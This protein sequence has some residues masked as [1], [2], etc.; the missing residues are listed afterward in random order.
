MAPQRNASKKRPNSLISTKSVIAAI[1]C[2][3]SGRRGK[4]L[5]KA[6]ISAA[7][8]SWRSRCQAGRIADFDSSSGRIRPYAA[9]DFLG[10][11]IAAAARE[12]GCS[13]NVT[14]VNVAASGTQHRR[15][16]D[17]T[18]R[19][20]AA[21]CRSAKATHNI[22]NANVAARRFESRYEWTMRGEL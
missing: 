21:P 16:T 10:D 20:L 18:C 7:G 12:S 11:D 22:S 8:I 2:G 15:P 17:I 6:C 13:E 9:I 4:P 5:R 3:S 14:N 19:D 1:S